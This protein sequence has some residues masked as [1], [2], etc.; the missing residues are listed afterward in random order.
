MSYIS[1]KER[2]TILID[3]ETREI[4]EDFKE[5]NRFPSISELIREK[6]NFCIEQADLISVIKNFNKFSHDLK[7]PLTSIKGFSQ[8][9]IKNYAD[10]IE[11]SILDKIKKIY[12]QTEL[13][14]Q[15]INV[16]LEDSGSENSQLKYD[17]LV[18]EDD[19]DTVFLIEELFELKS[20]RIKG[21]NSGAKG[22]EEL[23]TNTPKL[24]LLDILLPDL[25]G[26]EVAKEIRNNDKFKKIPIFYITAVPVSEVSKRIKDTGVNGYILKPFDLD[27]FEKIF[28]LL[29]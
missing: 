29:K 1:E 27:D 15:K 2:I 12:N 13:L 4:W 6:V 22:L 10:K 5:K 25:D 21:V 11:S 16:I 28:T 24:I 9:I 3:S 14:E 20:Y 7:E 23:N 19:P 26:Y 17:V 8:I 18:I